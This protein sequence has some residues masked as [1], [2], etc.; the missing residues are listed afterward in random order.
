MYRLLFF[1]LLIPSAWANS[2]EMLSD[3]ELEKKFVSIIKENEIEALI[4]RTKDYNE[5]RDKNKYDPNDSESVRRDKAKEAQKCFQDKISSKSTKAIQELSDNLGLESYQLVKSKNIKDIT[6][7]LGKRMHK[8]L[9]GINEADQENEIK[10]RNLK[11]ENKQFVNQDEFF[12]LYSYQLT[13]NALLEV[14]RYCFENL[15][16]TTQATPKTTSF[17]DHWSDY[18]SPQSGTQITVSDTGKHSWGDL[19]ASTDP[20]KAYEK[21]FAGIG[22]V[23]PQKLGEFW[24]FCT[25][26]MKQL[27][28]QYKPDSGSSVGA[29]SCLTMNRLRNIR[30]AIT[31]T[32]KNQKY[33]ADNM[34]HNSG[35]IVGLDEGKNAKFFK[36]EGENS[37]DNLTN[38]S[39]YDLLD[40][41]VDKS[42]ATLVEECRENP[43]K[44][45]CD[46]FIAEGGTSTEE[47]IHKIDQEMRFK[48]EAE[49]VRL[50]KIQEENKMS[51]KEYLEENG[52][53]EL[54]QKE[55]I[56]EEDI[57][58]FLSRTY[59]A[60]RVAVT[61]QLQK[62]VG[63][64]QVVSDAEA[65]VKTEAIK[66]SAQDSSEERTRLAQVILF[67]NIIT[68]NLKLFNSDGD[69]LGK[70]VGGWKKEVAAFQDANIDQRLYQNIQGVIDTSGESKN[71]SITGTDFIDS[72]IGKTDE[73]KTP[74]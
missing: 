21:I 46:K 35:T 12:K 62:S 29:N 67:N 73:S 18:F 41:N 71:N 11:F 53:F 38:V 24:N 65:E 6:E 17:L 72:I 57:R 60:Q 15:N 14:S 44:A 8:A 23:N 30:N 19:S 42:Y 68:A 7:Y 1:T 4:K 5:C 70:N 9:T 45:D 25:T 48:Q 58:D 47:L 51:F 59:D 54:A 22:Q 74:K 69:E 33:M 20:S 50:L 10:L 49:I 64:R 28:D 36:A 39:S 31:A 37:Y 13:K 66:A 2:N 55:D 40:G 27:C 63:S 34:G 26:Q 16:N 61:E 52:Y 3:K 43:E 56:K 32:E